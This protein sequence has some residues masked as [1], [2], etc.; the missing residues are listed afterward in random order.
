L[1]TSEEKAET[2]LQPNRR[3]KE[4]SERQKTV[5]LQKIIGSVK[6]G[7]LKGRGEISDFGGGGKLVQRP[8]Q[9]NGGNCAVGARKRKEGKR[10]K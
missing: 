7:G 10:S 1:K 6:M 4:P 5:P 2:P 9:R 8:R 3:G